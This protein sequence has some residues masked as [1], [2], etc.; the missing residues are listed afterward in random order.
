MTG[1]AK[2]YRW[3]QTEGN[4]PPGIGLK[5]DSG[6]LSGIP[7][8]NGTFRFKVSVTDT[9]GKTIVRDFVI[10]ISDDLAIRW[11]KAPALNSNTLSGSVE[12]TN[13]SREVFDITVV[14]VAVNEVGKAF[15]LGY[16]HQQ[17]VPTL[18]KEVRFS[19]ALPNGHYIVHADAVAEV[20]RPK[21]ITRV[22][23]QTDGPITVDVNR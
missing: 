9:T 4:L 1:G 3:A 10:E 6:A 23:L 17:L 22:R 8:E 13:G 19:A 18:R 7:T 11:L 16:E 5:N 15:T 14:V 21:R 20:P 2:P 12:V